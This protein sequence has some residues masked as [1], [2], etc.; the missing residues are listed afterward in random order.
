MVDRH[1]LWLI[2]LWLRAPVLA[3]SPL[4]HARE[5]DPI[6]TRLAA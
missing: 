6:G 2:E 3:G 1:G 4:I 5:A